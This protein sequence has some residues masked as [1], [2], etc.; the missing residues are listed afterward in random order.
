MIKKIAAY[1]SLLATALIAVP[2]VAVDT[3]KKG[4]KTTEQAPVAQYDQEFMKKVAHGNLAEIELGKLAVQKGTVPYVRNFGQRMIDDHGKL[5]NELSA[6][7]AQKG[8]KLPNE[9]TDKDK[10][11]RERLE[12]LSGNAFDRQ[13]ASTMVDEHKKD[14]A[15]FE[16]ALKKAKDPDLKRWAA[17]SVGTL[18]E[19]LRLAQDNMGQL[20]KAHAQAK[21]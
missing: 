4:D 13:Y 5:N 6:L 1:A 7:A 10:K 17:N 16:E 8:V 21:K 19:H 3:H 14:I 12:K 9:V 15:A 20:N 2:A 18:Q 11:L